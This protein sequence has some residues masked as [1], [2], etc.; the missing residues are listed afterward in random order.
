ME[1]DPPLKDG[2]YALL[3]VKLYGGFMNQFMVL[4][5]VCS[6][7]VGC[8]I[9]FV[10][11][12]LAHRPHICLVP[13][14]VQLQAMTHHW[15]KSIL[16]IS[17]NFPSLWPNYDQNACWVKGGGGGKI[18][19]LL[20]FLIKGTD[21]AHATYP[22]VFLSQW[23]HGDEL[24]QPFWGHLVVDGGWGKREVATE[25]LHSVWAACL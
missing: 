18:G 19:K 7:H 9:S 13:W 4:I 24:G 21:K 5:T 12:L 2:K 14:F 8:L 15:L 16:I 6:R 20:A 22:P 23:E 3:A 17:S 1:C 25:Q 10:P 11:S